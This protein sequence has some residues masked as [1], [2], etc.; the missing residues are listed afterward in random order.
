MSQ[1]LPSAVVLL[2]FLLAAPA[3]QQPDTRSTSFVARVEA[4][5]EAPRA[6]ATPAVPA[7]IE[8]VVRGLHTEG[9]D[10]PHGESLGEHGQ[11]QLER[12]HDEP[13]Q[14]DERTEDG[15]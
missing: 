13:V 12:D 15:R 5:P 7:D 4:I 10:G 11:R 3:C 6:R 1:H 2:G 14:R 8:V 9:E